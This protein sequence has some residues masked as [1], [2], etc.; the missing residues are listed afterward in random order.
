MHIQNVHILS[1]QP[2]PLLKVR[3]YPGHYLGY[4]QAATLALGLRCSEFSGA[5]ALDFFLKYRTIS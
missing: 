3:D 2:R 5:E 4:F 1:V